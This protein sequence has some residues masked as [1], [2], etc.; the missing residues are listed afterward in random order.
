M[1]EVPVHK[2]GPNS[3]ESSPHEVITVDTETLVIPGTVPKVQRLNLWVARLDRRHGKNPSRPRQVWGRG[4]TMEELAGWV[5]AQVKSTPTVWL[6]AHNLSFDLTTTRLPLKMVELGWQ[7]GQHN[8]AS[9]APWAYLKKGTRGLRVADS[10]SVLPVGVQQLAQMLGTAK[11]PLP[12]QDAADEQWWARCERDVQ[13]TADA[14]LACMDWWDEQQLGY[15]STTG[16]RTG[17]NMMRH[18]CVKRS[19]GPPVEHRGP[20]EGSW[21]QSGDG[22]VV[23]HPDPEARAWERA[24][25]Y[26]GRRE[27]W[28]AGRRP[29]GA[30]AELDFRTAHLQ[31]AADLKLPCRRNKAFESLEVDT[32]FLT[33]PQVGIIAD[34]MVSTDTPRYP[35]RGKEGICYPVGTFTTRLAGPEILEA[36][37]RGELLAIGAGYFYSLS[38]HMQPWALYCMDVLQKGE[39]EVPAAARAMVKMFT[40]RVFGV[41][42]ARTSRLEMTAASPITGWFAE[43]C[44]DARTGAPGVVLHLGGVVQEWTRDV[45]ADDAFPAV[46]SWVQSAVRVGLGRAADAIGDAGMV[47][48]STDSLLVDLTEAYYSN[49]LGKPGRADLQTPATYADWLCQQLAARCWPFQPRVK[50]HARTVEVVTAQHLRIGKERRYAGVPKGAKETSHNV[51]RFDTWPKLGSQIAAGDERGFV[52]PVRRV[53]LTGAAVNRYRFQDGCTQPPT[54]TWSRGTGTVLVAPV[55]NVCAAHGAHWAP[56]QWAGLPAP[57][58]GDPGGRGG[59][60]Q[61]GADTGA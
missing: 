15:W 32:V 9:S 30:Y 40:T 53:D 2:L 54:A 38:Y 35:W 18:L 28:V 61:G 12:D 55:E 13:V 20:R 21:W 31:V 42:A 10:F 39:Q 3:R 14:L 49:T 6:Y 59:D 57:L 25:L 24:T 17:W 45:D 11:T 8:L 1:R 29:W 26:Q 44:T 43:H 22:H 60:R 34:V 16:P 37:E 5:D 48:V 41:W 33:H 36:R 47:T 4:R 19:G 23:I 46:L 51:F 27:A 52:Q 50:Q 58:W 56:V 7:L